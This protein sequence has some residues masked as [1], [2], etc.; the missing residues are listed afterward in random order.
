MLSPPL[1]RTWWQRNWK[2][3]LPTA[4]VAGVV[5]FAGF[6]G[7]ILVS[8]LGMFKGSDPYRDAVAQARSSA[9]VLQELGEPIEPGWWVSGSI[10]FTG[11]S[12]RADFA[13][14]LSGS[15]GQGTLY[16][17]AERQA[18]QWHFELLEVA[19]AGKTQRIDLLKGQR[20][21]QR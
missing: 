11:S 6:V 12:G 3:F 17:R 10:N 16:V 18:G 13:T 20:A 5:T 19:V 15:S 9:S 1:P 8:V 14:P 4:I 2:W 7:V 21:S